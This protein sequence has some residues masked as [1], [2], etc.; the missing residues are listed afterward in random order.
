M[1][2]GDQVLY[3]YQW[4]L[5]IPITEKKSNKKQEKKKK[6]Y[7]RPTCSSVLRSKLIPLGRPSKVEKA[8]SP[9]LKGDISLY[10]LVHKAWASPSP[11]RMA[12]ES[13][14]A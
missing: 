13:S 14:K 5:P 3:E 4:Q 12:L 7:A 11:L 9:S 6:H 1:Y 10:S 8:I 2:W